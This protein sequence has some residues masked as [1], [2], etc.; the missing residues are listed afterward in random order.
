MPERYS[1]LTPY[2]FVAAFME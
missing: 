1:G 2:F